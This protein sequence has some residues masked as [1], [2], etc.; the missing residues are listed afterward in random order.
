MAPKIYQTDLIALLS[1]YITCFSSTEKSIKAALSVIPSSFSLFYGAVSNGSFVGFV[2]KNLWLARSQQSFRYPTFRTSNSN[3]NATN[4]TELIW[5]FHKN[6]FISLHKRTNRGFWV[7]SD[8]RHLSLFTKLHDCFSQNLRFH[9]FEPI[10]IPIRKL[11]KHFWNSRALRFIHGL[12]LPVFVFLC[13]TY[14]ATFLNALLTSFKDRKV[15]NCSS[16]LTAPD[17]FEILAG[18][19]SFSIIGPAASAKSLTCNLRAMPSSFF[20]NTLNISGV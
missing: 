18:V 1:P 13:F 17:L 12:Y 19:S 15:A 11:I 9:D 3:V 8:F 7:W 5:A 20:Y 14:C 16:L 6:L 10:C 2:N 4:I